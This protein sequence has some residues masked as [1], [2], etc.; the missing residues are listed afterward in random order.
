MKINYIVYNIM[1]DKCMLLFILVIFGIIMYHNMYYTKCKYPKYKTKTERFMNTD[2][3]L[4]NTA[5]V[6]SEFVEVQY[7]KDYND[8][9][10][11]IDNLT[12][13]KEL[14]NESCLPVVDTKPD[15]K[16][17][18][19]L[20]E[21]FIDKMN[22]EI[23][24]NVKEHITKNSGWTEMGILPNI[25][26]G[27]EK[28]LE[29]LGIPQLYNEPANKMEVK[30]ISIDKAEQYSTETQIRFIVYIVIQKLNVREQMVLKILF[31]MERDVDDKHNFFTKELQNKTNHSVK[32][33]QIFVL[34]YLTGST[35]KIK[36]DNSDYN[37]LQ[38]SGVTDQK[39]IIK[40]MLEKQKEREKEATHFLDAVDDETREIHNLPE[41]QRKNNN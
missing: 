6:N 19:Q 20:I 12:T 31:F 28:Q 25:K 18:K 11:A 35:K 9:I 33:E 27:S 14:F 39:T 4:H 10:N 22:Y 15:K 2:T 24:H 13:Q 8:T 16:I 37:V 17:V 32:I 26:S 40:I 5:Y 36:S 34:G 1:K 3:D 7:N 38:K 23:K 21:W 41:M 30:L 29:Y